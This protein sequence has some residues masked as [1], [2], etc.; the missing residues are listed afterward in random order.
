MKGAA[1]CG[2]ALVLAG[3]AGIVRTQPWLAKTVHATK[4]A[5][6]VYG[7]PPPFELHIATLGWDSAVADMLWSKLLVEYGTHWAEHR[8]FTGVPNYV[9]AILEL[10]PTYPSVYQFVD[11]L[12]AYR[13]LRGT[14][15]DVRKARAYLERG[16]RER[17]DDPK[18]W[19]RYGQFIA[20]IAPSFLND[21]AD[22]KAWRNDGAIAIGHAVELGAEPDDAIAAADML[23][24]AGQT[25]AAIRYLEHAYA[26]TEHP[27]MT[28]VHEAI[29]K[30][31]AILQATHMR[32]EADAV[33]R[34][35]EEGRRRDF[36]FLSRGHYLLLGPIANVAECAGF[37]AAKDPA[38]VRDWS[39]LP[40]G[41][42]GDASQQ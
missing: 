24:G 3:L 29:G 26:F 38:C 25:Q 14:E 22:R 4:E 40:F 28:E 36:P 16:T 33:L 21:D 8:D 41:A 10:E 7:L 42:P 27:S 32:D 39:S 1:V 5:D 37:A 19:L 13:P 12:L 34:A 6:E 20:F 15:D 30:R 23:R 35:V 2:A 18:L 31:L 9:D 11:T 17:P